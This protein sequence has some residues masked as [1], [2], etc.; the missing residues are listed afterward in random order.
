MVLVCELH[1]LPS[2][3]RKNLTRLVGP[4]R[5]HDTINIP[6]IYFSRYTIRPYW[7]PF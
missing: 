1:S 4:Q 6:S 5:T 3:T 2:S 7:H